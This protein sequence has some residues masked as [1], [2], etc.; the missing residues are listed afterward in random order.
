MVFMSL[1]FR[2]LNK[3]AMFR[4]VCFAKKSVHVFE[5]C[6]VMKRSHSVTR[7]PSGSI[8]LQV[9]QSGQKDTSPGLYFFTDSSR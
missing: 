3:C 1:C 7:N 9:L 5:T 2:M 6:Y 4:R 8:W